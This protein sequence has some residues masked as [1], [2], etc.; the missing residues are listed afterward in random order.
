MNLENRIRAVV[1]KIKD[2]W[3][4]CEFMAPF[5][6]RASEKEYIICETVH[7]CVINLKNHGKV[8]SFDKCDRG[9]H[10]NGLVDN[11]TAYDFLFKEGF[12]EHG[13]FNGKPTIK[14]TE[15]LISDLERF[16][17]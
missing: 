16:L 9:S 6:S 4:L 17:K 14:P 7:A 12:F 3:S 10:G 15:K 5:G 11:G 1:K 2:P 13:T 8:F